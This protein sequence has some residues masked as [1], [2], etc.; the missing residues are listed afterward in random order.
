MLPIYVSYFAANKQDG[1]NKALSNSLGFV[2]G[3]TI[4]F[5]ALGAFAGTVGSLLR[6]YS[7]VFN[8]VTGLVVIAFG[9]NFLGVLNIGFLNRTHRGKAD[10]KDLGFFSSLL[11]GIVF[12]IGW[13]PCVGAFLGSALMLASQQ[14]GTF[15][16][17]LMLLAFSAGLG[18]PFVVSAI[19][20]DKLKGT[21]D[22]IKKHY[23]VINI[24]SGGLLVV[25]G[26]LMATGLIGY[27]L[28]LLTF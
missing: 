10:T 17:I 1:K 16:G 7:T 14:G 23:R 26:I 8:I 9:L 12:S 13:T 19:L 15:Q 22:F 28:S 27:F 25:I 2:L 5:V 6:E 21:F 18:I 20:I 24:V 11:F 4:V 3:F